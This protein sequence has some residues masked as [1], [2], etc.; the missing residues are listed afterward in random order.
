MIISGLSTSLDGYIAGPDDGPELPLGRGGERPFQWFRDGDT[1]SRYYPSFRMSAVSAAFFDA[2]AGRVGA[3]ISGRRT[4][5]VS[6]AWGGT[7]PL[8]GVPCSS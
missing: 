1:P 5:D 8:P 7:G 4:Y 6:G 3:V 2:F